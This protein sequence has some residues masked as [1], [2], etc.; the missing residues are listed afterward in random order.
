MANPHRRSKVDTLAL[1]PFDRTLYLDSDTSIAQDISSIFDILDRFDICAAQA[2]LRNSYISKIAWQKSLPV[3]FP[4]FNTGVILYRKT[5]EVITFFEQWSKA[6]AEFGHR[7]DQPTFR[8]LL[9]SSK[10]R[11]IALPPEY[12]VRYL[13]YKFFWNKTE[14]VPFIY[15]LKQYHTGWIAW[16]IE[17]LKNSLISTI[18]FLSKPLRKLID[19]PSIKDAR[20]KIRIAKKESK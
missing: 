16:S 5:Q 13:K 18:D 7:H 15:H 4:P 14:A 2:M 17:M 8:E 11:V 20:R 10:L 9:W 1:T 12:N 3:G 19:A 6:F